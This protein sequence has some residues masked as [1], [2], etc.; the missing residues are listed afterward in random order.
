[1][2]NR[3]EVLQEIKNENWEYM[4]KLLHQNQ[5]DIITNPILN[6]AAQTFIS[7]FL[8][9]IDSYPQDRSDVVSH[10]ESLYQIHMSVSLD[11]EE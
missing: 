11:Q 9:N 10:L 6:I 8:S 3:E 5:K 1:M 7:E 2:I 4:I